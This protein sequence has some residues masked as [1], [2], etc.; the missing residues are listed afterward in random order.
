MKVPAPLKPDIHLIHLPININFLEISSDPLT[1]GPMFGSEC[2]HEHD[3]D[4]GRVSIP[5]AFP[6]SRVWDRGHASRW[7]QEQCRAFSWPG[8][9][10]TFSGLSDT[11]A[12][13][14]CRGRDK[15]VQQ[16]GAVSS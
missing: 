8:D 3:S 1:F 2:L 13:L 7:P 15:D 10:W 6:R 5:P 9:G 16:R 14:A 11:D 4:K 12:G